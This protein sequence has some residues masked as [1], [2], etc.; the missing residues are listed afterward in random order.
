M[1]LK[2]TFLIVTRAVSLLA[3]SRR[4]FRAVMF[5][6]HQTSSSERVLYLRPQNTLKNIHP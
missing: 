6:L 2:L 1:G 5:L 3:L 4:E